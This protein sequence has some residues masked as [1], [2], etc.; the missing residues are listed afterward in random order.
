MKTNS[1][2]VS[3][4]IAKYIA[5]AAF[6]AVDIF[7]VY[8]DDN[9][10]VTDSATIYF[11]Q[12]HTDFDPD[13]AQNGT[14]LTESIERILSAGSTGSD[15]IFS[16]IMVTG[17]ASPEG[18]VSFN[19]RLSRLRAGRI[20]DY[21]GS[22]ISLPD[23]LTVFEYAGRDWLGLRDMVAADANIPYREDVISLL[24]NYLSDTDISAEASDDCLMALKSLHDGVPYRYMYDRLFGSLRKSTLQVEYLRR[25][26]GTLSPLNAPE[27]CM[28]L[29]P[30][31]ADT[32]LYSFDLNPVKSCKPLYIGIKSNLLYDLLAVPDIGAEFYLGKNWSIAANWM[33]GWWSKDSRHRYWRIYGGDITVRRWF[34]HAADNKPL[35]GHHLGVYAGVVT[36]DFE[37]GGKG[38]MGGIPGGTLWDRC[39]VV[40]GIEYGYSLPVARRLN[41]D[42]TIGIGYLGGKYVKY[43]PDGKFYEWKSTNRLNYFGPTKIEVS[44]VWLIGCGNYNAGKGGTK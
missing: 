27:L 12:S 17:A 13:F 15:I 1:H 36:Y 11:R 41:I 44:L 3:T 39:Q 38:I 32:I 24:D 26:T 20:F 21:V 18:S 9:R 19:D 7:A 14:R 43:V 4:L 30:M 31:P 23:S 2:T 42:F 10:V 35:T 40:A 28:P 37:F 6:L 34:G 8:A 25:I 22:T 5:L 33:Y 29:S 16:K